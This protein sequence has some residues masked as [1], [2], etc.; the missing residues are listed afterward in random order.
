[1]ILME[2]KKRFPTFDKIQNFT[3]DDG[4]FIPVETHPNGKIAHIDGDDFVIL[5]DYTI[6]LNGCT[7]PV[8]EQE[9][10]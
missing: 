8:P 10:T 2:M 3:T 1:M 6:Y 7:F 9:N 5:K 4:D